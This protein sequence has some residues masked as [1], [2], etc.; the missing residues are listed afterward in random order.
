MLTAARGRQ[1]R[2]RHVIWAAG[3]EAQTALKLPKVRLTSTFALATRPLPP[4]PGWSPGWL[5]WESARPY[6]YV[7]NTNDGRLLIG[8]ADV[9]GV[10]THA[11]GAQLPERCRV[12][13]GR[14][15]QVLPGVESEPECCWG[16]TFAETTDGLP[17]ICASRRV[18]GLWYALAFGANGITFA[19]AAAQLLAAAIS[20]ERP[21]DFDFLG[22]P[23]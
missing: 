18:P 23:G 8:G 4:I 5:L 14:V 20:G 2:A 19:A 17:Y 6:L 1:I 3:Y 7:R 10:C 13:R 11:A 22:R 21:P 12:L 9:P 16:G 15:Q